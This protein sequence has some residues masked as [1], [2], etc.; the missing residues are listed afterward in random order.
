MVECSFE[1]WPGWKKPADQQ[2][3]IFLQA[4][5]NLEETGQ[6]QAASWDVEGRSPVQVDGEEHGV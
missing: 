6:E 5:S 2:R 4:P 1:F 3:I